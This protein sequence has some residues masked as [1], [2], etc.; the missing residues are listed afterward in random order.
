MIDATRPCKLA[1]P[2]DVWF[3]LVTWMGS[4]PTPRSPAGENRVI[5]ATNVTVKRG[6]VQG[7]NLNV[8]ERE[9][10][11]RECPELI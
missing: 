3:C 11:K 9:R 7:A 4:V 8:E 1:F 2:P 5:V 10:K 6:D